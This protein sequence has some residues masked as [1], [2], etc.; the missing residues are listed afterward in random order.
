[1]LEINQHFPNSSV[2][3]TNGLFNLHKFFE[4]K[5]GILISNPSITP[6]LGRLA[7]LQPEFERR[8]TKIICLSINSLENHNSSKED[9]EKNSKCK[10]NYPLIADLD[11]SVSEE[12]GILDLNQKKE[13][14][15]LQSIQAV[16]II[17]PDKKIKAAIDHPLSNERNF[18]EI[19]RELDSLQLYQNMMF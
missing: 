2:L 16:Y 15:K 12:L 13:K 10:V 1:M 8:E 4:D 7:E 17:S 9:I 11:G 19:L 5:W 6:E 14:N 18:D 3:T